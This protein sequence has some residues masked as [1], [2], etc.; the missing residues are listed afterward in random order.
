MD[1]CQWTD[2]LLEIGG[3]ATATGSAHRS[4]F[5]VFYVHGW[6]HNSAPADSDLQNFTALVAK[7][8]DAKKNSGQ[9]VVGVFIGWPGAS[10]P[11]PGLK[12]LTFWD[13][14][15]AAD[16]AIAVSNV[17]K[18]LGAAANI[19]RRR[20]DPK[21]FITAIGHSFGARILFSSVAPV[22]LHN[23]SMA[24]PGGHG[25]YDAFYGAANLTILLNPAFEASRFSAFNSNRRIQEQYNRAQ[26][27]TLLTISTLND[28]P[29]RFAFSAGQ[30]LTGR[31]SERER[32]TLGNYGDYVTHTLRKTASAPQ[33]LADARWFDQFCEKTKNERGNEETLCLTRTAQEAQPGNPFLVARTDGTILNGHNGIWKDTFQTWLIKFIEATEL[34]QRQQ[35]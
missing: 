29:T 16:R 35:K 21:D 15:N 7:L 33:Q 13:R 18:L 2:V 22:L 12:N 31:W 11:V 10:S 26:E 25:V 3:G 32:T 19:K 30:L 9:D 6:K 4:K 34:A 14:K 5:V 17:T 24:H 8:T 20:S 28:Y 27:P 23:Q 1:R